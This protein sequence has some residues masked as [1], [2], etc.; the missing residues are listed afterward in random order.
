M[1]SHPPASSVSAPQGSH[2]ITI[3]KGNAGSA[4]GYDEGEAP[5]RLRALTPTDPVRISKG[6]QLLLIK[7]CSP[8]AAAARGRSSQINSNICARLSRCPSCMRMDT[9]QPA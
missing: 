2:V 6:Q 8:H 4:R 5:R 7:T 1:P 3:N 9:W